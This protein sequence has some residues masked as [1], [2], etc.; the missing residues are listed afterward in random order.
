[1][2]TSFHIA[3]D[4]VRNRVAPIIERGKFRGTGTIDV[5][6]G[7]ARIRGKRVPSA[8]TRWAI[9]I[10]WY[11]VLV[12]VTAIA[13]NLVSPDN[14]APSQSGLS[15]VFVAIAYV[16]ANFWHSIRAD[17]DIPLVSIA[18]FAVDQSKHLIGLSV[19]TLPDLSPI[20]MRVEQPEKVFES[21]SALNVGCPRPVSPSE[22]EPSSSNA[23]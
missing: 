11:V 3:G 7:I 17:V 14:A 22:N 6:D 5:A 23:A 21:L 12:A 10:G 16:A 8:L 20:V 1:M 18:A 2:A 15:I 9:G 19:P 13:M 4:F